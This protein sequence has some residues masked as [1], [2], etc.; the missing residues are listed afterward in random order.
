M[1]TYKQT[2]PSA[3]NALGNLLMGMMPTC[4]VYSEHTQT[5]P[6]HPGRHADVLVTALGRSPV[7]VEAEFDPAPEAEKDA[8]ERLGLKVAGE[9][10]DIEAA[11]AVIYPATIET[12][13]NLPTTLAEATLSYCVLY[14]DG[15]RFPEAGWLQG[16]VVDLADLVRLVSV[17]QKEVDQAADILE[18][19]IEAAAEIMD[20][21]AEVR[22]GISAE[23]AKLLGMVDV[24]Q[25]RRMAC[26]ILANA[27]VFHERI[28][29]MHPGVA[30]L[31]KLSDTES[32]T[33][34]DAFL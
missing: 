33:L 8:R 5:F 13:Y 4:K 28:A 9:P 7:A 27:L 29:G 14:E 15:T 20:K 30:T 21:M 16:T 18:K 1:T 10:R 26:A 22:P 11:V 19:G 3:N 24:P 32:E 6:D 12:A 17:P 34:Q 31:L 23:I 25:T 2:E